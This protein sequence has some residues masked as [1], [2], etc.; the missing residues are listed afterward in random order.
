MEAASIYLGSLTS[1]R[2]FSFLPALLLLSPAATDSWYSAERGCPSQASFG[3]DAA[4]GPLEFRRLSVETGRMLTWTEAGLP[5]PLCPVHSQPDVIVHEPRGPPSPGLSTCAAETAV[6]PI[7]GYLGSR[8]WGRSARWAAKSGRSL[9]STPSFSSR[10][11]HPHPGARLESLP[12]GAR[13]LLNRILG[14][15]HVTRL[16]TRLCG[17]RVVAEPSP[18]F[19]GIG[20]LPDLPGSLPGRYSGGTRWAVL[21]LRGTWRS[22][23]CDGAVP[24][25]SHCCLGPGRPYLLRSVNWP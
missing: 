10:R 12:R 25:Q 17:H 23:G 8:G 1:F 14:T 18:T 7:P 24:A 9:S 19:S 22:G 11:Q 4:L 15:P 2:V 16:P 13:F 3:D 20:V 6:V 5:R 21:T